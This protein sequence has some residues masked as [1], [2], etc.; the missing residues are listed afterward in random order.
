MRSAGIRL[1][2][3]QRTTTLSGVK[4]GILLELGFDDTAPNR[5]VTISSWALKFA[6]DRGLLGQSR[7]ECPLLRAHTHLR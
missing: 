2:Y 3:F 6:R 1:N 5:A 4:N 7:C